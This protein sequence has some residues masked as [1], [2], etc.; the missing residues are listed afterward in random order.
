LLL[1]AAFAIN[2][3][4]FA[5]EPK[6]A[7]PEPSAPS[8]PQQVA[9][10]AAPGQ[11]VTSPDAEEQK[12]QKAEEQL[13]H[14]EHQRILGVIPAFNASNIPDAVS[15]TSKQKFKLAFRSAIDPFQFFTAAVGAGVSQSNNSYEEYG[16]GV[17]GYA[18]RFGAGYLDNFDGA[19]LGNAVFPV[20][21]R[22]DPRYFR[23]GTGRFSSRFLY[24]VASTVR[25]K[26]DAGHWGP[27]Y[28]NLLGNLAAGGISNLYYPDSERGASLTV[29]RA[30][31]VS[32]YGAIGALAYEFWP[33]VV[34]WRQQRHQH[35]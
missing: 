21:F 12:R 30:I 16:Q 31:V 28:G 5:Q 27:N 7:A 24:A 35:N 13:K 29:Q 8:I 34:R 3:N 23:K 15:L 19:I 4:A 32:A 10:V 1:C 11:T 17:E 20:I 26:T 22:E 2:V 33:D 18:K 9:P 6:N 14:Q 25:C